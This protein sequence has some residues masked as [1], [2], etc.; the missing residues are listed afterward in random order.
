MELPVVTGR[1]PEQGRQALT[2][3]GHLGALGQVSVHAR[4]V[5][6]ELGPE[7]RIIGFGRGADSAGDVLNRAPE[8]GVPIEHLHVRVHVGLGCAPHHPGA[9]HPAAS[10]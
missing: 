10:R 5:G 2:H 6:L 3:A 7:F 1:A 9:H 4:D 8:L